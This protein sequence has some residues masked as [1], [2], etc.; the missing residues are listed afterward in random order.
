MRQNKY[1]IDKM[2]PLLKIF[3]LLIITIISSI[4]FYPFL[5]SVLVISG[6]IIEVYLAA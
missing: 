1:F 4:D 3:I 2:N 6:L 5:S